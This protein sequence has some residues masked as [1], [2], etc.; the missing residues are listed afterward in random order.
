VTPA[1]RK[2]L[3]R[4]ATAIRAPVV[5]T[6]DWRGVP[7]SFVER[8][9]KTGGW[10]CCYSWQPEHRAL[11]VGR[12]S[13]KLHRNGQVEAVCAG[14]PSEMAAWMHH[15]AEVVRTVERLRE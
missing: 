5:Y 6:D 12:G 14:S 15:V 10:R 13:V 9:P 3:G 8:D 1:F 7:G 2:A 4:F 11:E